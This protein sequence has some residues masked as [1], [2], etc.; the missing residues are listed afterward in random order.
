MNDDK[1]S[2]WDQFSFLLLYSILALV[3]L[4]DRVSSPPRI[5]PKLLL[6]GRSISAAGVLKRAG[7]MPLG[8]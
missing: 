1:A 8:V 3:E 7:V 5:S 4:L 2:I 6:F